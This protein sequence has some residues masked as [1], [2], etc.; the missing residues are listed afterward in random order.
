MTEISVFAFLI[1]SYCTPFLIPPCNDEDDNDEDDNNEDGQDDAPYDEL[2]LE[3][4]TPHL[5][6]D[7]SGNLVEHLGTII[8]V[9]CPLVQL[10]QLPVA[11]QR[12]VHVGPHHVH[13]LVHLGN[14]CAEGNLH[15]TAVSLVKLFQ[16]LLL[17]F[18]RIH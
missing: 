3:V 16:P 1:A 10:A 2:P 14:G 18:K 7:I 6:V 13:H 9:L 8:Q 12:L 5:L 15:S 11:L 17:L 4:L